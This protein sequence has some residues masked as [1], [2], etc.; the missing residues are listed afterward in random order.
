MKGSLVLEEKVGVRFFSALFPF[1]WRTLLFFDLF[2]LAVLILATRLAT[3]LHELIGHALVASAF[4]GEVNGVRMS[5]F[6][7]GHVYYF[8]S[9]ESGLFVRLLV[10]FGG[11]IVNMLSGL[12]LFIFIRKPDKRSGWAFFPILFGMVSLLGAITYC[13][14]GFYYDHGDPVAW[15]DRASPYVGWFSVPFLVVSPFVSCFAL[16]AYSI[17]NEVWFPTKTYLGRVVMLILTLGLTGGAYAGLFWLTDQRSVA[18]DAPLSAY[19]RAEEDVRKWKVEELFGNLRESHP[20]LSKTEIQRLVERTPIVVNPDE[21]PKK[22]PLKP[23]IAILYAAGALLALRGMREGVPDA[24]P[25]VDTRSFVIAVAL[26]VA[27]LGALVM[28]G[29]WV[30]RSVHW[31]PG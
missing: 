28:S 12:L 8:L 24:H 15:A 7:G 31:L 30:Y 19:Q 25:W 26:A 29:G 1:S 14:L 17:I 13:A 2:L 11:I 3:F 23:V 5:L 27:V 21:V 10:A 16:K 20:Q 18:L 6:G 22:F 9:R 4:G